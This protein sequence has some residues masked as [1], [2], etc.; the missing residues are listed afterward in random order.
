V[1][2]DHRAHALAEHRIGDGHGRGERDRRVRH[3]GGLDDRRADVLAAA[4]DD[5]RSAPDHA[6]H[7]VASISAMSPM[8]IQ[9][10]AVKSCALPARRPSSPRSSADRG[11][12]AGRGRSP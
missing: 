1:Q 4:D 3:H 2:L 5:V 12:R 9:P 6:E 10:S 8:S 7:A 11:S